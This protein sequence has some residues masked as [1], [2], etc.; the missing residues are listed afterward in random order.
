MIEAFPPSTGSGQAD[1]KLNGEWLV[2]YWDP[3]QA[4][5]RT[6]QGCG[7]VVHGRRSIC[8]CYRHGAPAIPLTQ[9]SW[10]TRSSRSRVGPENRHRRLTDRPTHQASDLRFCGRAGKAGLITEIG[11]ERSMTEVLT[12]PALSPSPPAH[13]AG[14]SNR[15]SPSRATRPGGCEN[16]SGNR[17]GRTARTARPGAR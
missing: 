5:V 14:N 15:P 9:R 7:L 11:Q 3:R 6:R 8:D 13:N 4:R 12:V 1:L 17:C 2:R 16:R 10:R